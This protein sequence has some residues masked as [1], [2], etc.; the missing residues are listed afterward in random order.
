MVWD[1]DTD[2]Y[3]NTIYRYYNP[4]PNFGYIAVLKFKSHEFKS[5]LLSKLIEQ[6]PKIIRKNYYLELRRLFPDLIVELVLTYLIFQEQE[7]LRQQFSQLSE[8][9][10]VKV[11]ARNFNLLRISTGL[12]TGLHF[13]S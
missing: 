5:E 3:Q 9:C 7:L 6:K 2:T 12:S 4:E 1:V 11:F 10:Y 13:S 8:K